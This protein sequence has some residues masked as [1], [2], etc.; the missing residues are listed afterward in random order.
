MTTI[1]PRSRHAVRGRLLRRVSGLPGVS[2][3]LGVAGLPGV[4][5]LLV[6]TVLLAAAPAPPLNAAEPAGV[7]SEQRVAVDAAAAVA[8]ARQRLAA[9]DRAGAVTLLET[10]LAAAPPAEARL[11]LAGLYLDLGRAAEAAEVVAP[12]VAPEVPVVD[13]ET[14]FVAARAA[15]AV[16]QLERAEELLA[17]SAAER[18]VSWAAVLLAD[19]R[20]QQGRHED[21][22]ALLAPVAAAL[23]EVAGN[24]RA[25]G[26]Q[27][28]L[29]YGRSLM[30][31]GRRDEAVAE[32]ARA[33]ELAPA[34]ADSWR[35][36]GET[37]L[38]LER[39]D[40]ARS[41]LARAQELEEAEH[42][43]DL[44]A[45]D[46]RQRLGERLEAAAAHRDAGRPDQ[47]LEA[48]RQAI[49]IDP[50]ALQPRLLEVRLLA[51]LE[52]T[53]EASGRA[54]EL[55]ERAPDHPDARHLRGM[56][57]LAAGDAAGAEADLRHALAIAPNHLGAGNGLALALVALDRPAEAAA[58]LD[59]VLARWPDD[60]LARRTRQRLEAAAAP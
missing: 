56:V 59:R 10:L 32:L 3:L 36:L 6:A 7:P 49:E 30:A 54:D 52:R 38:E 15:L 55:V 11:L 22:A 28:A 50:Q 2:G 8:A 29:H 35:L 24:D 21:A 47:A 31:L 16:G 5:G 4:A 42:R 19:L 45:A 48:L 57:R 33:A 44:A 58:V 26:A 1:R 60:A 23:E 39:I 9:G 53:A 43:A 51:G 41:A 17:R 37:L 27:I 14:L 25:L 46:Q 12:L 20:T 13:G 18:P 40:E 34:S